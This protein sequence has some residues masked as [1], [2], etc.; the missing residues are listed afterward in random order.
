MDYESLNS[1]ITL[2]SVYNNA[3]GLLLGS[4][5]TKYIENDVENI[6]NNWRQFKWKI[7]NNFLFCGVY[8]EPSILRELIPLSNNDNYTIRFGNGN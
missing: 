8:N 2:L 3:T 7:E 1:T 4:C 5:Q 6:E